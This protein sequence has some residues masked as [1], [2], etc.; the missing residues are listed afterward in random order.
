MN[1]K[2]DVKQTNHSGGIFA[3]CEMYGAAAAALFYV[4][5]CEYNGRSI[6]SLFR[7]LF[8]CNAIYIM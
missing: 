1:G 6:H 3:L 7:V 8:M 2:S 5:M 4:C